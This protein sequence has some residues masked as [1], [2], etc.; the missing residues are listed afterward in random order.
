MSKAAWDGSLKKHA[1]NGQIACPI[2][3][4]KGKWNV[5]DVKV[6]EEFF[7]ELK[8]YLRRRDIRANL[9]EGSGSSSFS[10]EANVLEIE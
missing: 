8:R 10:S 2:A 1:K 3:G 6:D 5:K 4:C 7:K 9:I